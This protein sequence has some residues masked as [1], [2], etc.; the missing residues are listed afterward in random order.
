MATQAERES[1]IP[2]VPAP[3][4]QAESISSAR[5]V[6]DFVRGALGALVRN[7]AGIDDVADIIATEFEHRLDERAEAV[8]KVGERKVRRLEDIKDLILKELES[9]KVAALVMDSHLR[10]LSANRR[11][12]DIIGDISVIEKESPLGAFVLSQ[13]ERQDVDVGGVMRTAHLLTSRSAGGG[14]SLILLSLE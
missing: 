6:R 2:Q 5:S 11:G 14:D 12:R 3:E 13:S 8:R 9:Y 7:E 1:L 10:I 4:E